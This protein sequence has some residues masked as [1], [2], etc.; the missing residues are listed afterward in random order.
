MHGFHL[1][2]SKCL[3]PKGDFKIEAANSAVGQLQNLCLDPTFEE[4]LAAAPAA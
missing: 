2:M 4:T 3:A 1:L